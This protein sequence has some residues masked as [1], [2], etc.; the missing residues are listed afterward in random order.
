MVS[1]L[2]IFA[3]VGSKVAMTKLIKGVVVKDGD[4][5]IEFTPGTESPIINGIE[6]LPA[7]SLAPASSGS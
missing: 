5:S 7:G 1:G 3:E 4:L 2:D 6:V